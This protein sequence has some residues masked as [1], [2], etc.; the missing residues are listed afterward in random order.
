MAKLLFFFCNIS[1]EKK[2]LYNI[3]LTLFILC[4]HLWCDGKQRLSSQQQN[5]K[6]TTT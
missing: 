5:F 4:G 1:R 2:L 6:I 3:P